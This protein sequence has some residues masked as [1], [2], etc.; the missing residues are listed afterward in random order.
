[1]QIGIDPAID[2]VFKWL[3]GSEKNKDLLLDIINAVMSESGEQQVVAVE[4]LSPYNLKTSLQDKLSVVDVRAKSENGEWYI[5]EMQIEV[6][7]YFPKRLLYYW[8]KMYQ[9]QLKESER[10]DL[11]KKATLICITKEPM[12][13][14]SRKY[15]NH[16]QIWEKSEQ[17]PFCEDFHI[18]TIEL[19]KF[20]VSVE[21]VA[22]PLEYWSYFLKHG[23]ELEIETLPSVF[24]HTPV[25]K[26]VEELKMFTQDEIARGLYESRFKAAMDERSKLHDKYLTGLQEG[27]Q[28]GIQKGRQEGEQ[29]S[30]QKTVVNALKSGLDVETIHKITGV[31]KEEIRKLQREAKDR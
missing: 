17:I 31:S 22:T 20:L 25:R 11:L 9:A 10:Y 14:S 19:P 29:I 3:F 2:C 16:F 27:E 13:L 8:A 15:Y 5:L 1:M 28:I 12:P 18:H 24:E 4:L 7:S 23:K 26:A 21:E 6:Q 30:I